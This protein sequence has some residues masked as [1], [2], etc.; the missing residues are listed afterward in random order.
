[1]LSLSRDYYLLFAEEV[2]P[3]KTFVPNLLSNG[4]LFPALLLTFLSIYLSFV[5]EI[6][7]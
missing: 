1:M 5:R 3:V 2:K 4:D 6:Y 7:D